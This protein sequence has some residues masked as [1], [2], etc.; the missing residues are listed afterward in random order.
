M[1]FFYSNLS[2]KLQILILD[3]FCLNQSLILPFLDL[4]QIDEQVLQLKFDVHP[5]IKKKIKEFKKF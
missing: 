1:I 3:I 4:Y 5:K 2:E